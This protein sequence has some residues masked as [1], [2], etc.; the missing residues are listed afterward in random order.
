MEPDDVVHH[1]G[2][3]FLHAEL[4]RLRLAACREPMPRRRPSTVTLVMMNATNRLSTSIVQCAPS[5]RNRPCSGPFAAH[6]RHDV[7]RGPLS[8]AFATGVAAWAVRRDGGNPGLSNHNSSPPA[9]RLM[10]CV[11]ATNGVSKMS[12]LD[13]LYRHAHRRYERSPAPGPCLT[14]SAG[15]EPT[16]ANKMP[17]GPRFAC[18]SPVPRRARP[19]C[20]GI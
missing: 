1:R 17:S 4:P 12:C 16:R 15:H 3:A 18:A 9:M 6:H 2:G 20:Q 10:T 14:G 19:G 5:T 7:R 8:T 13:R 11:H